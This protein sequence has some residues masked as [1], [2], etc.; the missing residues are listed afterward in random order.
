MSKLSRI[1][2]LKQKLNE[3]KAKKDKTG[4][5]G[6]SSDIYPFWQME[7]GQQAKVRILPD[8]NEDNPFLFYVDKLEHKISINGEDKKI[9]CRA[10][11]GEECPI[12]DL[13]RKYYKEEGKGSKNGK[14]YYR[15][16]TSL[17][18][19][20]VVEDPLP[21]NAETGETYE[22]KVL[23]TQFGYQ[24]MEKIKEQISSDDLGDFTD[25]NEGYDFIIKKTPQGE[26]GT[27]A[28]GS[29]FARRPSAVDPDIQ[30]KIEL[31]DLSTLLPRDYGYEK[32]H[33]ML[34]AHLNGEDYV[35]DG[36]DEAP[37]KAS[38][39]A[40]KAPA[41][42]VDD[43]DEDEMPVRKASRQVREAVDED[44]DEDEEE[45]APPKKAAKA[46]AKAVVED[47]DEDEDDIFEKLRA[48]RNAAKK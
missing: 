20:L 27:Y 11:H 33:N 3:E 9:P 23:N 35:E 28:V 24:L 1:E 43:E 12:C 29:G 19:V 37:K 31:I 36:E 21:A 41:R 6:Y 16:K 26:Y 10:M 4:T 15:S 17:V 40:A 45:V 7:I 13:S 32:V 42:K 46:P 39:P 8:L 47:E 34:S 18:R 2:L 5:G 48:R 22:G 25:L 14:Y 38:K 30:E 44:E